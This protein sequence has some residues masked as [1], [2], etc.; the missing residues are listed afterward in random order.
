VKVREDGRVMHKMYLWQVKSAA[1]SKYK[2]DLCKLVTTIE[3]ADAWRPLQDGGC[4]L[5]KV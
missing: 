3:P 1:E 2:F 4:P 5:I